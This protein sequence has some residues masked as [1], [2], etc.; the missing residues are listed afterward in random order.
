M[1]RKRKDNSLLQ[2]VRLFLI[3]E[4]FS[5]RFAYIVLLPA[6]L[7]FVRLFIE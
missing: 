4:V 3:D 6:M 7:V 5:I 2:L 1:T